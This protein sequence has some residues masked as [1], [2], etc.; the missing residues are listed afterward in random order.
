MKRFLQFTALLTLT[1]FVGLSTAETFHVH[2]A[3]QTEASC[4]VCQVVHRTPINITT[5]APV[6]PHF[7]STSAYV[8]AFL[9]TDVQ[10]VFVSHGLSPP[11]L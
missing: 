3:H 2:K 9:P 4:P 5:P 7:I 1:A 11:V 8:A 10:F 6:A